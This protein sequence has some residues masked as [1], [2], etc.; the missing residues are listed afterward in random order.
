MEEIVGRKNNKI[1]PMAKVKVEVSNKIVE[2]QVID[3]NRDMFSGDV[4]VRIDTPE[5]NVALSPDDVSV[6]KSRDEVKIEE[7]EKDE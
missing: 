4:K 6:I 5:G 2:G 1:E 7:G 3:V